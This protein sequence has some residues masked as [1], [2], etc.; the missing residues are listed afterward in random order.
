VKDEVGRNPLQL[1]CTYSVE[2]PPLWK[3][4]YTLSSFYKK[5]HVSYN[6]YDENYIEEVSTQHKEIFKMLS[7]CD[8]FQNDDVFEWNC[9]D[10]AIRLHNLFAVEKFLGRFGDSINLEKLF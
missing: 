4:V 8:V 10:Y 1:L 6:Y 9:L 3:Q 7:H 2:H 5:E